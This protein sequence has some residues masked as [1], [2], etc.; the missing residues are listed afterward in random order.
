[1]NIDMKNLNK[2]LPKASS[3]N[4]SREA[5]LVQGKAWGLFTKINTNELKYS[6]IG[7]K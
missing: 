1:M 4:N 3:S 7:I 6:K 5:I 2:L